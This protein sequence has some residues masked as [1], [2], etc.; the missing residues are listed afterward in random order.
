[1]NGFIKRLVI[2]LGCLL[3]PVAAWAYDVP[4]AKQTKLG[5][6]LTAAEAAEVVKAERSQVLF[7][8]V[9]ARSEIQFVGYTSEIDGV[10][11]WVDVNARG[12]WDDAGGRLKL[13]QNPGFSMAVGALL[14]RKG[15]AK[16]Q[17]V[18][19]I[20][21][22]GDR[23]AKAANLL[24]DAGYTNVYSVIEGFE[25]DL[26]PDGRRTVNGWKN[27]GLPW[28]YKLDKAKVFPPVE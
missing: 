4:A 17:K 1:M 15:L 27:A 28:T 5:K 18:I 10:V 7:V 13:E 2:G 19:L 9:R 6:Y 16:D 25:G 3:L 23:S 21:R 20:C 11:P 12:E 22:S 14:A 8:D 24:A 26:S